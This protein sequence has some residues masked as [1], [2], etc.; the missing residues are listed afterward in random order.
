MATGRCR[1]AAGLKCDADPPPTTL[2]LSGEL[3]H[4]SPCL[5]AYT[6]VAGRAAHWRPVW[7]HERG[8]SFIAKLAD[9]NWA[10]QEEEDVGEDTGSM[11]RLSAVVRRKRAVS[12]PVVR[13]VG[14]GGRQGC[15]ARRGR[16]EVRRV[17][18][19]AG[20]LKNQRRVPSARN[21][22]ASAQM[23]TTVS[24]STMTVQARAGLRGQ[25]QV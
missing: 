8:N 13:G 17:P 1:A 16:P 9:G 3:K 6:L 20:C 24:W 5:G 21:K 22:T 7:R 14:R 23:R 18:A 4:Q 25:E 10:V 12:A 19:A 11:R 2:V 15:V